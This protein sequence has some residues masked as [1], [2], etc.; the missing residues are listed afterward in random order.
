MVRLL[1]IF[2]VCVIAAGPAFCGVTLRSGDNVTIGSEES[3][4]ED[5]T[6]AGNNVSI[7]P[8]VDGD[9]TAAGR[10]VVVSGDVTDSIFAAGNTVNVTGRVGNDLRVAGS[11]VTLAGQVADNVYLAGSSV[12]FTEASNVA[13]DVLAVGN[14]VEMLGVVGGDVRIAG[15]QITIRGTV[16]GN[17][18]ARANQLR[19]LD[20]ATINGNLFYESENEANIAPG[21]TVLGDIQRTIPREERRRAMFWPG[22]LWWLIW[23]LAAIIFSIVVYLLFPGRVAAAADTIVGSLWVSI[24]I[25]FLALVAVP[26]AAFILM[27]TVIGIPLAIALMVVYFLLLY[28]AKAWVGLAIGRWIF[29]RVGRGPVSPI[30]M[31]VL[32]IVVL[33]IVSIIPFIG[34]LFALLALLA[35]FGGFLISVWRDRSDSSRREVV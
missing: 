20:G 29:G 16:N 22:F 2:I 1:L 12:T 6:V 25:G 18:F 31:I 33:E 17:V 34:W 35:G 24:G 14:R 10:S 7:M 11:N 13:E 5:L 30:W 21:A 15:N 3:I 8:S 27:I 19:I 32:G 28:A 4:T 9:V 23:L 26:V